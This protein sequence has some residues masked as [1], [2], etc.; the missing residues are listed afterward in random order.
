MIVCTDY[1]YEGWEINIVDLNLIYI[2]EK[3]RFSSEIKGYSVD[4][5]K[6]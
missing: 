2:N 1:S 5:L 3:I 4:N 6:F